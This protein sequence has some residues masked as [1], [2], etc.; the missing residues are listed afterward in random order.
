MA[1]EIS[2]LLTPPPGLGLGTVDIAAGQSLSGVLDC[3]GWTVV[4]LYTPADW[5]PASL[6]FLL[7]NDNLTWR[8]VYTSGG[9]EY[10]RMMVPNIVIPVDPLYGR[11]LW[12]LRFRSGTRTAP[13]NQA[14]ARQFTVVF[15]K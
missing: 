2:P 7:S 10:V 14:A 4:R 8:D 1:D 15:S 12:F 5:T 6:T 11:N 13:V 3:N 9:F